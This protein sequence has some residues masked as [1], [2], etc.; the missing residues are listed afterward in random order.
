M[1]PTPDLAKEIYQHL[2]DVI[3]KAHLAGD[4]DTYATCFA[5]PH[6]LETFDRRTTIET[7]EQLRTAF[8]TLRGHLDRVGVTSLT[9]HCTLAEF[10]DG[11]TIQGSHETWLVTDSHMIR[12]HY[13]ALMTL[14]RS[15]AGWRLQSGQ[16]A[17][18]DRAMPVAL[19]DRLTARFPGRE[20]VSA[21]A[22]ITDPAEQHTPPAN[23]KGAN[24]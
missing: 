9:R 14:R 7:R 2:L 15:G 1:T 23:R 22:P 12:D 17:T 5:L 3:G 16:Y 19:I 4:F 20:V 8:D 13:T 18:N 11:D 6:V 24:P 10:V 21:D